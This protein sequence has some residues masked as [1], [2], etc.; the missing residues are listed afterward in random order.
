MAGTCDAY[1]QMS[2]LAN[3]ATRAA[4]IAK[5]VAK[6]PNSEKLSAGDIVREFNGML[7]ELTVPM[8]ELRRDPKFLPPTYTNNL[9]FEAT[10]LRPSFPR[11]CKSKRTY[12]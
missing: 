5:A 7:H 6:V 1:P 11:A 9:A 2:N 4:F 3:D 8:D 10:L 12:T